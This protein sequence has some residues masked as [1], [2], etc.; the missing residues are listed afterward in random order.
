T[1]QM[2]AVDPTPALDIETAPTMQMGAWTPATSSAP[3]PSVAPAPRRPERQPAASLFLPIVVVDED[4]DEI[5]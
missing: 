4:G 2:P 5:E 3:V 1:L